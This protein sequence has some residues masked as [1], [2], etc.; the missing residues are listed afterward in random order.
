MV[1]Q[2]GS[3]DPGMHSKGRCVVVVD[4]LGGGQRGS[5]DSGVHIKSGSVVVRGS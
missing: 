1:G 4:V 5:F 2:R 3:F